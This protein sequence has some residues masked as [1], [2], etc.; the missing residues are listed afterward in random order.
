MG[1][2]LYACPLLTTYKQKQTNHVFGWPPVH[3]GWIDNHFINTCSNIKFS[4]RF[5]L[6]EFKLIKEVLHWDDPVQDPWSKITQIIANQRNCWIHPGKGFIMVRV[7]ADHQSW[8]RSFQRNTPYKTWGFFPGTPWNNPHNKS[9]V[10][11]ETTDR[12]NKSHSLRKISLTWAELSPFCFM[13]SSGL[14]VLVLFTSSFS[15]LTSDPTTSEESS[16][17]RINHCSLPSW[18]KKNQDLKKTICKCDKKCPI[19]EIINN[20]SKQNHYMPWVLTI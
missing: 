16:S 4:F 12:W 1:F 11:F 19:K 2:L 14:V 5:I 3:D 8:S 17:S 15:N 18:R 9:L 6:S 13:F 20:Y 10:P 7:I